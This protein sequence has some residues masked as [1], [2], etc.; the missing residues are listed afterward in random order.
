MV[1]GA[2]KNV[3]EVMGSNARDSRWT[4]SHEL[5]VKIVFFALKNPK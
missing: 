1:R 3:Q 4:F 2:E 5:V